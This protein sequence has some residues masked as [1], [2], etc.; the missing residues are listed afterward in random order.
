MPSSLLKSLFRVA[1]RRPH[2]VEPLPADFNSGYIARQTKPQRPGQR[3]RSRGRRG[4]GSARGQAPA[5]KSGRVGLA[6]KRTGPP[7]SS[8]SAFA[9]I[10]WQ[11]RI[12]VYDINQSFSRLTMLPWLTESSAERFNDAARHLAGKAGAR[13]RAGADSQ[14][15]PDARPAHQRARYRR[16]AW[17]S[18]A[19][20]CARPCASLQSSG[21]VVARKHSGVF[22][23]ELDAVRDSR[24]LPAARPARRLCRASGGAVACS[25][26]ER[27]AGGAG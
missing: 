13:R 27:A 21:L 9:M 19:C 12:F 24:P 18:R 15:R 2:G 22:V 7:G 8:S 17:A 16:A 10:S 14:R 6:D 4:A 1:N 25:E 3:W 23:R 20:R 11:N 5:L 26:K